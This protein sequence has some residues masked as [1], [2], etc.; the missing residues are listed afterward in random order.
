MTLAKVAMPPL[1]V[2]V[3][4]LPAAKTAPLGPLAIARLRVDVLS[5]TSMLPNWSAMATSTVGATG[6]AGDGI[7]RLLHERQMVR[8]GRRDV[9]VDGRRRRVRQC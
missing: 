2:A 1:T 8:C 3:V 6:V 4:L 9:E 5:P 7:G